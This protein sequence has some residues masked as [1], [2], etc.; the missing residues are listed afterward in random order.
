L[1]VAACVVMPHPARA[2]S[3]NLE[4][5]IVSEIRVTGLRHLAPAVVERHLATRVGEPFH[6][7]TL[8]LDRRRLDELRLF[9]AVAFEPRLENQTVVLDVAV[10]ETMRILPVVVIRVTDENG[11]SVGPGVRALNL[12]GH[13]AQLGVSMRF[14]GETA[15]GAT[16]DSTTITPGTRAWHLGFTDT[17]RRNELHDFDEHATTADVRLTRTR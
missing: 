7:A 6:S 4:G 12:L 8:L 1:I 14:G 16:V 13:G 11:A 2:Q 3:P 10:A 5:L 9:T 15:F 17:S